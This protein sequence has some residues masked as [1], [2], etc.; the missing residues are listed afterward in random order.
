MIETLTGRRGNRIEAPKFKTLTFSA[1]PT[2]TECEALYA[3]LN[4]VRDALEQLISRMD[5]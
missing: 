1:T 2:Q 5:G 3:Y 4:T